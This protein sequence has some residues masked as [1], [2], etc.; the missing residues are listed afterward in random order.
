MASLFALA[1]RTAA[2]LPTP[3]A[4]AQRALAT[5]ATANA[6]G[7]KPSRVELAN[8]VALDGFA[9]GADRPVSGEI[10]FSTGLVGYPESMSDPSYRGQILVFTQPLIGNYGVPPATKDK[11]GL[12]SFFESDRIQASGIIVADLALQY[13]HWN[14][15]ESLS[16]WCERHGV[17]GVT[18]I[19][20]R[21][22]TKILR[23]KGSALGRIRPAGAAETPF[24]NPNARNLVAEVSTKTVQEINPAGKFTIAV[25]DCGAK[26]NILRCL[27][28]RDA[29]ILLLPWNHDLSTVEYDGLLVS[30]G[31]GDPMTCLET[32][33]QLA[34]VAFHRP[35][36]VFG[37]CM[38]NLLM[39]LAAGAQSYK[40]QFGNRGHNQPALFHDTGKAVITSQNH[41]YAIDLKTL[42]STWRPWFTNLNDGSNEG[43]A[44]KTMPYTS[45]QFHPE[46]RGGPEDTS[47]LFDRFM[48]SVARV[49]AR[50]SVHAGADVPAA[51]PSPV[52][53]EQEAVLAVA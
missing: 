49:K 18:G 51:R 8:G 14:A 17:P 31:P 21:A 13:S 22:L 39:G 28:E 26:A 16:S 2:R 6:R 10:V 12:P 52:P 47:F 40:L 35:Q 30:N 25:I 29:R 36:P 11:F 27:A 46:Y 23:Q 44:H 19:D 45:V 5:A 53:P 1:T 15:V 38:G 37:I 41:G 3:L 20:T 33:K 43:L 9:F 50:T 34:D 48:H 42:P 4:T 24:E 32:V 7:L